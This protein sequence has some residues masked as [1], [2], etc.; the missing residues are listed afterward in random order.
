MVGADAKHITLA[1]AAQRLFDIADAVNAIG[2]NPSKGNIRRNRARDH[3]DSQRGL[4]RKSRVRR[5][6]RLGHTRRIA[7]PARREI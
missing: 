6:M 4:G 1:G 5:H 2:G 7:R 3:L